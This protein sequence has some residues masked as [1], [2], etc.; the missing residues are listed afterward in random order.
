[1]CEGCNRCADKDLDTPIYGCCDCDDFGFH[2]GCK[3][4]PK[5]ACDQWKC[6]NCKGER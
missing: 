4:C 1:M 3:G 6:K 5:V 2:I